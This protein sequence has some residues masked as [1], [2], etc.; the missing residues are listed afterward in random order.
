MSLYCNSIAD[1]HNE[2]TTS[3]PIQTIVNLSD[4]TMVQNNVRLNDDG[5]IIVNIIPKRTRKRKRNSEAY[6]HND[7]KEKKIKV[8]YMCLEK[9]N[10]YLHEK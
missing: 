5:N 8:F 10:M 1:D 2:P 7:R 6:S 9:T 4:L 3:F